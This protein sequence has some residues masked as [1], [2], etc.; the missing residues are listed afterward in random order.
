MSHKT[1]TLLAVAAVLALLSVSAVPASDGD[2]SASHYK[3]A[4]DSNGQALY[5][6]LAERFAGAT[7]VPATIGITMDVKVD[8]SN[9]TEYVAE[10]VNRTLAA[11]YLSDPSPIWLWNTPVTEVDVSTVTGDG[12]CTIS[13]ELSV[14][15]EFREGTKAK[16][17]VQALEEKLVAFDGTSRE[18]VSSINDKLRGIS[19]KTDGEAE[20]SSVYDALVKGESSSAGIAAAFTCLA[21]R[22]GVTVLTVYGDV[23]TSDG[24]EK[25]YW[26]E[27]V[28]DGKWYAVDCTWNSKT[29]KNCLLAGAFTS[30]TFG[31]TEVGFGATHS[32]TEF[33]G[34]SA[35]GIE[36]KGVDWPDD[37]SFFEKYGVYIFGAAV[38]IVVVGTMIHAV[39]AGDI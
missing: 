14:P 16:E 20:V 7:D 38:V 17:A 27:A 2:A 26:N 22:S 4:L 5:A 12:K 10:M 9:Q 23:K 24:S 25:G 34:L 35:P 32:A 3:D 18:K 1:M 33:E 13:F 8:S 31:E 19:S 37:R 28:D 6:V 21:Q 36:A 30:V 39:R 11:Y 15:D 29:S